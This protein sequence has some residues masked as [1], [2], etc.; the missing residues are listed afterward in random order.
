MITIRFKVLSIIVALL[1]AFLLV[2]YAS[3][4][5]INGYLY[6]A[7][8]DPHYSQASDIITLAN[9]DETG[10]YYISFE[11][12]GSVA[13]GG[14]NRSCPIKGDCLEPN[15][16]YIFG[17]L[18]NFRLVGVSDVSA[19]IVC[20]S[21]DY[22]TCSNSPEYAQYAIFD[23]LVQYDEPAPITNSTW[24]SD[25]GFWGSTTASNVQST[26]TAGVQNTG[27]DLWGLLV[28]AGIAIAF[29][30][31]LQLVF[32][33]K[34][35]VKPTTKKEFD[36]VAFNKKADELE[37]FFSRTGGADPE[38]VEQIKRKRGRPRKNPIIE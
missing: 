17:P 38:L 33:T 18:G 29:I 4:Q 30:I 9:F 2:N 5:T 19:Y 12:D 32:L 34:K 25:N 37:E 28:F 31:F 26:L 3:A 7:L 21:I 24:G 16:G 14:G 10:T 13:N 15:D 22:A 35:S 36:E 27:A 8:P 1:G 6:N 20:S 11:V 23:Y